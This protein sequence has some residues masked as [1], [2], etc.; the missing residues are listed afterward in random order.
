MY[1]LNL[2][3]YPWWV[4]QRYNKYIFIKNQL[5]RTFQEAVDFA[6]EFSREK[7]MFIR[8]DIDEEEDFEHIVETLDDKVI[9]ECRI[10]PLEYADM[11]MNEEQGLYLNPYGKIYRVEKLDEFLRDHI[12]ELE[13]AGYLERRYKVG[14]IIT[15]GE[16]SHVSREPEYI[17]VVMD[18]DTVPPF[19]MQ[20]I[21]YRRNPGWA[22]GGKVER[23]A[24]PAYDIRW[25]PYEKEI[26]EYSFWDLL[27]EVAK[28]N[29]ELSDEF[30]ELINRYAISID[31]KGYTDYET[32]KADLEENR[33][34]LLEQG[35]D[36]K[37]KNWR[38][39]KDNLSRYRTLKGGF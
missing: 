2:T 31:I 36:W 17:G 37:G 25:R 39:Y 26:E 3:I 1:L 21:T 18:I 8:K 15:Y 29:M 13:V 11:E 6:V 35:I 34:M 9:Y 19:K 38:E 30:D 27:V 7:L 20:L 23:M 10:L 33:D 5:F 12:E 4:E 24:V 28:K 16:D 14:D 32:M 22:A